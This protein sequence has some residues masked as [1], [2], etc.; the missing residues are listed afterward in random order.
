MK[1]IAEC[2]LGMILTIV[3][4]L[5]VCSCSDNEETAIDDFDIQFE[6]PSLIEINEGGTYTFI[7]KSKN[8]PLISDNLS[9]N[10]KLVFL[11]YVR[12]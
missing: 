8:A 1:K 7:L 9:W 6:L 11:T 10:R 5:V 3:F 4:S 2:L 12:L